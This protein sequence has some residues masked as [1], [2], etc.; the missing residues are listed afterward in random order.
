MASPYV[1]KPNA[2]GFSVVLFSVFE[3]PMPR[4]GNGLRP[5]EADRFVSDSAETVAL[6]ACAGWRMLAALACP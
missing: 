1:V 4:L 6:H 2:D 3:G 5:I